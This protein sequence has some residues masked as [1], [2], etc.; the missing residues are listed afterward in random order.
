MVLVVISLVNSVSYYS[1]IDG[2]VNLYTS[3]EQEESDSNN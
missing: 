3:L 2:R 1:E